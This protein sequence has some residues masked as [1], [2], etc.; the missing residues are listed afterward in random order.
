MKV[1]YFD[2]I[3]DAARPFFSS[4]SRINPLKPV[5]GPSDIKE[6]DYFIVGGAPESY[7]FYWTNLESI[8]D[9]S[10]LSTKIVF[11]NTPHNN[12]KIRERFSDRK[13]V[14]FLAVGESIKFK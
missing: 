2:D 1:G 10:P 13:N 11:M 14:K 5:K 6:L 7:I 12:E 4:V 8:I 9:K 3:A